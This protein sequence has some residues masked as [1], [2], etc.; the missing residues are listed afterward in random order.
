MT[1]KEFINQVFL[2]EYA[3][4]VPEHAYISF[5]LIG[6]GIE[7]LG[8]CLDSSPF[9]QT[10]LSGNRVRSALQS[11]FPGKYH[12]FIDELAADL[13][14]GFAHQFRPGRK[15]ELSR[16]SEG[17]SNK[18][19]HLGTTSD[20]RLC[21]FI[22]DFYDDFANACRVV[23]NKIDAGQLQHSKLAAVYLRV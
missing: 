21:L 9:D 3:Q 5:A 4:I 13:R 15:L 16:R 18:W 6:I 20:G 23:I 22:E 7:F 11:L 19:Q 14:N 8:A 17:Q 1:P 2:A 10:G 12:S